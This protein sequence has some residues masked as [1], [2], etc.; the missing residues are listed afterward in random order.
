MKLNE[1][2]IIKSLIHRTKKISFFNKITIMKVIL[3][4]PKD[5][6]NYAAKITQLQ[7][8]RIERNQ[9]Q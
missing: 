3:M 5:K 4:E 9:A 6:I 8:I 2:S 7:S 1:F